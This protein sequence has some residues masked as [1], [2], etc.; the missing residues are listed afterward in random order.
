LLRKK[1]D[2]SNYIVGVFDFDARISLNGFLYLDSIVSDKYTLFQFVP[3][4]I[5]NFSNLISYT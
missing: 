5:L 3:K 2:L 4:P 1:Y